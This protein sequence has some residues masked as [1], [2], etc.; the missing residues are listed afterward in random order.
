VPLAPSAAWA[1]K[2]RAALPELP[3]ARRARL[4]AERGLSGQDM[5]ALRNA[6]ALDL[7]VATVEAGAA[8]ADARKWWLTELSRHA[9]QTGTELSALPVTPAQVAR[10]TELVASGA[11]NDRLARQVLAAVLAGEGG[12]DEV[13]ASRGLAVVSDEGKLAAVVDEAIEANPE[14]A[15]RVRSGKVA[16]ASALAGAVMKTTRGQADAVRARELIL[17]RLGQSG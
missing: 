3:A 10:V 8:P 1:E 11:L 16:A 17:Q 12:P 6:G 14:V 2:L 4:Q 13:I 5:S 7:V 15:G 9:N